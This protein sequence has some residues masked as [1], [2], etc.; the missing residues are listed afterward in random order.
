VIADLLDMGLTYDEIQNS[1]IEQIRVFQKAYARQKID[2]ELS[3]IER[4]ALMA[5]SKGQLSTIKK[6]IQ[7]LKMS[8]K[9]VSE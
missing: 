3:E 7:S 8:R 5:T 9:Q 4:L 6:Q 1:D 2:K